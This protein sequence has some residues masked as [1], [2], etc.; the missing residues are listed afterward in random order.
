MALDVLDA[1]GRPSRWKTITQGPFPEQEIYRLTPA[2]L[3]TRRQIYGEAIHY[4]YSSS[5]F[6]L[7][8][9]HA[10]HPTA[11]HRILRQAPA[12]FD[13]VRHLV[14]GSQFDTYNLP[15]QNLSPPTHD[16]NVE[17]DFDAKEASMLAGLED[18]PR[19]VLAVIRQRNMHLKTFTLRSPRLLGYAIVATN[20]AEMVQDG[21]IEEVRIHVERAP[22]RKD[23]NRAAWGWLFEWTL[24]RRVVVRRSLNEDG[25]HELWRLRLRRDRLCGGM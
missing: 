11:P 16:D 3:S 17:D 23:V 13:L 19:W 15:W 14:C 25:L 2:L 9:T 6:R 20:L 21:F 22:E 10:D 5:T 1:G 18:D 8:S 4:L 24:L 12:R 7:Y